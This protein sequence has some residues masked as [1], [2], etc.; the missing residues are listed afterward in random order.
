MIAS[1]MIMLTNRLVLPDLSSPYISKASEHR[2][3]G[4]Q[5]LPGLEGKGLVH[6]RGP[7]PLHQ[8]LQYFEHWGD[9]HAHWYC[10]YPATITRWQGS[11]LSAK[12]A[13]RRKKGQCR[14]HD[15]YTCGTV[16]GTTIAPARM[17]AVRPFRYVSSPKHKPMPIEPKHGGTHRDNPASLQPTETAVGLWSVMRNTPLQLSRLELQRDHV[18]RC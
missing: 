12:N 2:N 13:P 8:P 17:H 14:A 18:F 15:C 6:R 5:T 1:I 16:P 4:A 9:T 10:T 11:N 3:I 7:S